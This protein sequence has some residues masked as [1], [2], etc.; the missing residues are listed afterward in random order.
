[1]RDIGSRI[2]KARKGRRLSQGALAKKVK[3]LKGSCDGRQISDWERNVNI[4]STQSLDALA[5]AL[6]VPAD[7]LLGR[8]EAA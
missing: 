3:D 4:P 1:M 5:K 8:T 2:R 7:Y 6:N